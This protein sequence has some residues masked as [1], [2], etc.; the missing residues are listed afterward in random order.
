MRTR[1]IWNP[2]EHGLLV[3][4]PVLS[5]AIIGVVTI[6]ATDTQTSGFGTETT[7]QVVFLLG[8]LVVTSVTLTV[9]YQ[10]IGRWA[11]GLFAAMLVLLAL[12]IVDKWV[13]LPLVP[14]RNGARRWIKLGPILIQPSEFMKVA[15]IL[16]LARYLQ[17]RKNYRR[18][19]GLI[20]P[21]LLTLIPMF[22]ILPEPDLGTVILLLPVF[23]VM[24]FAAGARMLHF[25]GIIVLAIC[26]LPLIWNRMQPYQRARI[27]GVLMQS[28]TVR[29]KIRGLAAS[30]E[31]GPQRQREL[32]NGVVPGALREA[33]A[34][35]GIALTDT[36]TVESRYRGA[37]WMIS[38]GGR[39]MTV[40]KERSALNAYESPTWPWKWLATAEQARDWRLDTGYQ[41]RHAKA[42]LGS[43]AVSGWGGEV[44]RV[45][46]R[47]RY[48][49][50][51]HNDFIF[52][53][54]GYRWGIFGTLLIIACYALIAVGGVEIAALT[55]DPFG[56]LLAVG[57]VT[58]ISAQAMINIGMTL[59]LM[60]ITGM[61]LPFVS[62]GG[63]SLL[64]NFIAV[65][66][67]IN[68]AQRRPVV[69]GHKPF[70]FAEE[71]DV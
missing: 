6:H 21:F 55:N 59:G 26:A 58:L 69:I 10:Q 53:V 64:A 49:K 24:L 3:L 56:R 7:K 52:A 71:E 68:I 46:L 43:G 57:V 32:D 4:V 20:G 18:L 12:L 66:L 13:D 62:Y 15:F 65:G 60:P 27:S 50:H 16:T 47:D 63:S 19:A 61:T 38:S 36:P 14:I 28:E 11:Y 54:I 51:R 48:L 30:T 37:R 9:S 8:S 70:S 17:F 35:A 2:T 42:A 29:N 34:Q 39:T 1:P 23:F 67:L 44:D 33:L 41:L 45:V 25:S 40:R 5:L 31:A 22:L